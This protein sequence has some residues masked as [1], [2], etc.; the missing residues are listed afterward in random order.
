VPKQEVVIV[1]GKLTCRLLAKKNNC[2]ACHAIDH[3]VVGPAWMDVSK[4]YNSNGTTTTGKKWP[5]SE[6]THA[7]DTGR[8]AGTEV[9]KGGTGNWERQP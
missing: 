3:K 7:K 5:T 8:V 6:R 1:A 4:A 2:T 9:S